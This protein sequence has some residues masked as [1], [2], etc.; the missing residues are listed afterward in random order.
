MPGILFIC[1]G[2]L[3]RSPL[4]AAF[5]LQR[6]WK[7]GRRDGW[8]IDSAGTWTLPGQPV[9]AAVQQAAEKRGIHLD[10]YRSKLVDAGLLA[11][12]DLILV[13]ESGHKEALAVEFPAAACKT[14]L[15][16]DVADGIAYNVPDPAATG[17]E[18]EEVVTGMFNLIERGY[19]SICQLAV[20]LHSE[21]ISIKRS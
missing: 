16:S 19:A 8:S 12:F 15:L 7:D 21:N 18:A 10:E 5:F 11:D 20:S 4:A 17:Q 3:F 9:P 1:T 6:L 2:N 14:F 13:M